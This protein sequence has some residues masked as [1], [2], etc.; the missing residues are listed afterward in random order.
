MGSIRQLIIG[1]LFG[2]SA[3]IKPQ[4]VI[5]APVVVLA[6]IALHARSAGV[7]PARAIFL[8][9]CSVIGFALPVGTALLWLVANDAFWPFVSLVTDYL[10]LHIQQTISNS[11]IPVHER[12]LYLLK[13]TLN[14]DGF[15]RLL[16]AFALAVVVAWIMLRHSAALV[17]AGVVVLLTGLYALYPAFSGQFWSYHYMPF[18][19]FFLMALS[20]LTLPFI[21]VPARPSLAVVAGVVLILAATATLAKVLRPSD[22]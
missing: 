3:V 9:S 2:L 4:L 1:L 6:D 11:F 18:H 20:L 19:Y 14:L 15:W 21:A 5:G 7:R 8:V 17:P 12:P 16:P 22:Y 10:P 13:W